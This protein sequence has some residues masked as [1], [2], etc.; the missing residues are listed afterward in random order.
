MSAAYGNRSPYERSR[1]RIDLIHCI[2]Y[3]SLPKSLISSA[4]MSFE[5]AD[6]DKRIQ[7]FGAKKLITFSIQIFSC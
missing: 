7:D 3:K 2:D 6:I 1:Y 4:F 5:I